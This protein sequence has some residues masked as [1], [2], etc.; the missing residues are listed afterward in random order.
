MLPPR[1]CLCRTTSVWPSPASCWQKACRRR[2]PRHLSA[3]P[4]QVRRAVGRQGRRKGVPRGRRI[5]VRRGRRTACVGGVAVR[6]AVRAVGVLTGR[7]PIQTTSPTRRTRTGARH[8]DALARSVEPSAPWI[9]GTSRHPVMPTSP[10]TAP[11]ERQSA[12]PP[13]SRTRRRLARVG[14]LSMV[15]VQLGQA[16]QGLAQMIR[17]RMRGGR[18]R[19]V[20]FARSDAAR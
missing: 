16:Q 1:R 5:C 15:L 4:T 18:G 14:L 17:Q 2:R 6:V 9:P 13:T 10:V 3:A 12:R 20:R 11:A 7:R 19:L 8:A